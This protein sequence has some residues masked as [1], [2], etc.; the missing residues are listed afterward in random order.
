MRSLLVRLL[1]VVL[2]ALIPSLWFQVYAEGE[3]RR[4]RQQ[5]VEDEALRTVRLVNS[6]QQRIIEG[7]EQVL[8]AFSAAPSVEDLEPERCSRMLK[9]LLR[10]SPRYNAAAVIGLDGHPVCASFPFES[11]VDVSDRTYFRLALETGSFVIGD[12]SEGRSPGSRSI[13]MAKPLK[14]RLVR[15]ICG[16]RSAPAV[17][18]VHGTA[19][20]L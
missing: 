12:Y 8:N 20:F 14:N 10:A 19:Q 11:G 13:E 3:A 4:I 17:C 18:Q 16:Q 6:E 1:I 15:K 7:A 9:G 2:F 5:M